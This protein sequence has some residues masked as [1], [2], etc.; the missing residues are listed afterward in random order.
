MHRLICSVVTSLIAVPCLTGLQFNLSEADEFDT[1]RATYR[2]YVEKTNEKTIKEYIEMDIKTITDQLIIEDNHGLTTYYW[3]NIDYTDDMNRDSWPAA[4]HVSRTLYIAIAAKLTEDK[5]IAKAKL[6]IALG[7]TYY[8]I[9]HNYRNANWWQNELGALNNLGTLGLYV[10]DYLN[11]LGQ[12][13]F[14]GKM[15]QG[16]LYYRPSLTTH[17]GANL[18]DYADI[19]LKSAIITKNRPELK[20]TVK[21][22][23]DEI[24]YRDG[25]EGFQRDGSFFQHGRQLQIA[26]YGKCIIR[27]GKLL[28]VLAKCSYKVSQEKLNIVS[29]YILTGLQSM[30]HKGYINYSA[31]SREHCRVN[32]L[33]AEANNF[34]QFEYYTTLEDFPQVDE[35]KRYLDDLKNKKSNFD[36]IRYF[37]VA[38][39]VAMNIDGLYMSFKG[40]DSNLTNT[41]CVNDE[42]RLGLNLSYGTNT[43]V[44]DNGDEYYNVCPVWDFAYI[45]GTT[46]YQLSNKPIG[47]FDP[48][49]NYDSYLV[50]S[51]KMIMDIVTGEKDEKGT[52]IKQYYNDA[53][54]E[55]FL[56]A[57]NED[58]DYLYRDGRDKNIV[59]ILQ[60]SCH[61][62]EN[63]FTVTSIATTEGMLLLGADLEYTGEKTGQYFADHGY[64]DR[65][66]HTTIEQFRGT[67][68]NLTE[69]KKSLTIN[70]ALYKIVD[71]KNT[72]T[73]EK[74]PGFNGH[75]KRN[76]RPVLEGT[77]PDQPKSDD[78]ILAYIN[79]GIGGKGNK[80][81][82]AY[83]IQPTTK[84]EINFIVHNNFDVNKVQEVTAP[85]TENSKLVYKTVI[86]PYEDVD[87]Y[88]D[89]NGKTHNLKKGEVITYGPN[90]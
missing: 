45:P 46:S 41:E 21:R 54:Y 1:M 67:N 50:E 76:K 88:V 87:N 24:I 64:G 5:E 39:M 61:H 17:T 59:Y 75:W 13:A 71:S 49:E 84:S 26:S 16:S 89:H 2:Q 29:K 30:T 3:N 78:V 47:V 68:A 35:L 62:D 69:D 85:C 60:R 77:N 48:I 25:G 51:D 44:M 82:Y 79:H 90:Q 66:L 11:D 52:V 7:L 53:L 20:C 72:I 23:A 27:L 74:R 22:I 15:R 19:T 10:Y 80:Y 12:S 70:N 36:G 28:H 43:C 57:A 58:N 14:M 63:N 81:Q 18:F 83:S 65:Y 86:V 37:D 38:K 55:R 6:N 4:N 31:V 8:W 9:F 33:D 40:T 34:Q 32:N 73:L 42:N 56:P